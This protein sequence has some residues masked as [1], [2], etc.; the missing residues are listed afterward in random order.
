MSSRWKVRLDAINFVVLAD[1]FWGSGSPCQVCHQFPPSL[2]TP[3]NAS[4]RRG[5]SA[6]ICRH[7]LQDCHTYACLFARGPDPISFLKVRQQQ[8]IL[9]RQLPFSTSPRRLGGDEHFG[10]SEWIAK[11]LSSRSNRQSNGGSKCI[12]QLAKLFP[13]LYQNLLVKAS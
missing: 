3:L 9:V 11:R 1:P 4:R 12:S 13:L 7:S 10:M 2:A 5:R 6:S 8:G